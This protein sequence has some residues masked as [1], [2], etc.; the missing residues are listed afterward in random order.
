MPN[1]PITNSDMKNFE[2][3]ATDKTEA[4]VHKLVGKSQEIKSEIE[5]YTDVATQYVQRHPVRSTLLAGLAGIILGK[6]LSK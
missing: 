1:Q 6:L 2:Q 5:E 4:F 3:K